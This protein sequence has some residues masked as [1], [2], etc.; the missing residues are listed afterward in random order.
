M[1]GH[2]N[3]QAVPS[4]E[5]SYI[6][7][8]LTNLC[9]LRCKHCIQQYDIH[10]HTDD[11]GFLDP[12]IFYA[13]LEDMERHGLA[14]HTLILFWIGEPL[15]HPKF[16]E[17]YRFVLEFNA[18]AKVFRKV[19]VHTNGNLLRPAVRDL[20]T[21]DTDSIFQV[22][23]C[24]IDAS[25]ADTYVGIK[26]KNDFALVESNVRE[27]VK[28]RAEKRSL[29]P[30]LVF[31]FIVHEANAA[32]APEFQARWQGECRAHGLDCGA[33]A[34]H[35]VFDRDNCVFFRQLDCLDAREQE[36]S[37]VRYV[38]LMRSL[39]LIGEDRRSIVDRLRSKIL[40][41]NTHTCSGF[42]KSPVVNW[43][44]RVTTCT[45]DNEMVNVLG[46]LRTETFHDVWWRNQK[47]AAWRQQA[48]DGT[49]R[50][51]SIC[52]DCIIPKSANYTNMTKAE[53]KAYRRWSSRANT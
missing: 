22:W 49:Y 15:M 29:Y 37:N 41:P 52:Q 51:L 12:T 31:Q 25:R 30:K 48:I 26:G 4:F 33:A 9:N 10:P 27:L 11:G 45:R 16:A 5:G 24:T 28:L 7:F 50:D 8:E 42:F 35:P 2:G 3:G 17:L 20:A 36:A 18:R 32:E 38:D 13:A 53:V 47:L 21:N 23:H 46:D 6:V 40:T 34:F 43:D 39:G 19:E 44:G 1:N 14:F